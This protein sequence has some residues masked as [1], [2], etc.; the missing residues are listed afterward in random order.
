MTGEQYFELTA[1]VVSPRVAKDGLFACPCCGNY[2]FTEAGGNEICEICCWEDDLVQE[3]NPGI[4]GGANKASLLQA[5]E[6][7]RAAGW[8]NPAECSRRPKLP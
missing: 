6:N 3:A 7:F 1:S 8:S 5:R 4:S 2:S